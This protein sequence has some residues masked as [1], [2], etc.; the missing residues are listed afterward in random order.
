[1]SRTENRLPDDRRVRDTCSIISD[2]ARILKRPDLQERLVTDG[3]TPAG[4]MSPEQL[5]G[6]VK[7]EIVKWGKAVRDSGAK[8]D[9]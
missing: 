3:A 2:L 6:H 7:A 9:L 4:D 5:A 1:M 8:A